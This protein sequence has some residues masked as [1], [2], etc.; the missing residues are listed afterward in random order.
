[1]IRQDPE[2]RSAMHYRDI[3]VIGAS[4]GGVHALAEL[5]A[6][7]PEDL[8]VSIFVVQHVSPYG[9]SA[10]PQI[11]SRSGPLQAVH[12]E[13]NAR[14]QKG[15]IYVAP[16]DHH[17]LIQD[18]RVRLSR[19]P[20]E[21]GHRPAVDVLFR[22]AA[23]ACGPRAVGVI[24]TG[25]LDDGTAGLA[26]I[27]KYGGVAV[28]QDPEEADYP[29]MPKS[30]IESVDVDHVVSLSAISE[31]LVGLS[32]EPIAPDPPDP[33]ADER[34]TAMKEELERGQDRDENEGGPSGFTCPECGGA[35]WESREEALVHFRCRTGHAFSPESLLAEQDDNLEFT[36]WAA[37]RAFQENADLARRMEHTM[38]NRG[39]AAGRDRYHRR[40][41]EADRH[42]EVLRRM[43][44]HE[45]EHEKVEVE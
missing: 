39:A 23:R 45:H 2:K 4:A 13:D 34:A 24:L 7:L 18:G 41:E 5:V 40:A 32:R 8:P 22:S 10:M 14:I 31:L 26:Q 16:P 21:N 6:G 1:M 35:L 43:L 42:A 9:R 27:K 38:A 37:V 17:L 30:A 44:V 19:A 29:G 12:P 3:F 11:L 20:S 28:V 15:R 25:N 36:L 33:P